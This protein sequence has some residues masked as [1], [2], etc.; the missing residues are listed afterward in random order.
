MKERILIVEDEVEL[1]MTLG[2]RL[3]S[4]GY[5]VDFAFD[6][7]TGLEKMLRMPF[8]LIVLDMM[9]PFK[10]GLELCALVR[11]HSIDTPILV[12]TALSQPIEKVAGLKLGADDYVTKPFDTMELMARVEALLRRSASRVSQFR[13]ER[14]TYR[15]GDLVLDAG[16]NTV[17]RDGKAISLTTREFQ[18]LWYLAERTGQVVSRDEL[19]TYVWGQVPGTLTRTVDMHVASLRQKI[20]SSPKTPQLILTVAGCG[21]KLQAPGEV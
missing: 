6:G 17:F 5:V 14:A 15:L 16:R 4:Q 18:L 3:A 20:E 12:L 2:D 19:L 21:Y 1:C 11:Q 10:S 13:L 8:N 9:L 7:N